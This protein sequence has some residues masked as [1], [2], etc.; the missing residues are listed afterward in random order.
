V[1][2]SNGVQILGPTVVGDHVKIAPM[3]VADGCR[4]IGE[5]TKILDGA[6]LVGDITLGKNVR[7]GAGAL[8]VGDITIGEGAVIDPGVKVT[9]DVPPHAHVVGEVPNLPGVL[10][11]EQVGTP[12]MVQITPKAANN[13][14]ALLKPPTPQIIGQGLEY[15]AK[16]VRSMNAANDGAYLTQT[17]QR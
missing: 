12:I 16:G 17:S 7:I 5:G 14:H 2:L 3:V 1:T 15:L 11:P 6:K 9:K 4:A 8:V 10:V 13:K